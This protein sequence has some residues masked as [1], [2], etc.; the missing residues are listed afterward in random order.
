MGQ[1]KERLPGR[2]A[3]PQIYQINAPQTNVEKEK[4]RERGEAGGESERQ[5]KA[6]AHLLRLPSKV[7]EEK[8]MNIKP[9]VCVHHVP[10]VQERGK[11]RKRRDRKSGAGKE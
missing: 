2:T 10:C 9:E 6:G 1:S 11:K 7:K 3:K 4:E 8:A 5:L